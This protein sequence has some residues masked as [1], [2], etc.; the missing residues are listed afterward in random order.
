MVVRL[1][2][3][4]LRS[5]SFVYGHR[6]KSIVKLISL[7]INIEGLKCVQ[8][9]TVTRRALEAQGAELESHLLTSDIC[10]NPIVF[11]WWISTS[12]SFLIHRHLPLMHAK[13][14]IRSSP[15]PLV[16][17]VVAG[18]VRLPITPLADLMVCNGCLKLHLTYR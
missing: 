7:I 4:E 15:H 18:K 9:I 3:I 8:H 1:R 6:D 10:L 14:N 12:T 16:S 17:Q 13:N 5:F 11:S 2:F